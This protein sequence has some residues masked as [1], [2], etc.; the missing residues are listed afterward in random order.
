MASSEPKASEN[1]SAKRTKTV[2]G[3]RLQSTDS[4][5]TGMKT[6]SQMQARNYPPQEFLKLLKSSESQSQHTLLPPR[7]SGYTGKKAHL[8]A[9]VSFCLTHCSR[10]LGDFMESQALI[11]LV[12]GQ[13]EKADLRKIS[14]S[15]QRNIYISH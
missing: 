9:A 3:I 15:L 8:Q 4:G 13:E 6:T 10:G 7:S 14:E 12:S 2:P 5:N 1:N 11:P